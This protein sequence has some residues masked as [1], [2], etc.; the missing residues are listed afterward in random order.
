MPSTCTHAALGKIAEMVASA[1]RQIRN[2][3]RWD[4]VMQAM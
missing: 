3:Y 1:A 4:V 2:L